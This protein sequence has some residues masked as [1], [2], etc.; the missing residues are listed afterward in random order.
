L[1]KSYRVKKE[2]EFQKIFF[3]GKSYANKYFVVYRLKNEHNK[4][5]RIGISV[6]K[7]IGCAVV[8]NSVKRKIRRCVFELTPSI[9]TDLDFLVI[10]RVQITCLTT[11]ELNKN[12][13]HV[14]NLANIL[15]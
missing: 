2:K 14:L 6:G 5:F 15:K 11:E 4:H 10:A 7:K 12:L 9:K 13:A 8:R 1:R 3:D